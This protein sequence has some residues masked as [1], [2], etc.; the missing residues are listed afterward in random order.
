M[1]KCEAFQ[2]DL[3]THQRM[4]ELLNVTLVKCSKEVREGQHLG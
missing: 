4:P 2:T 3:A 1:G